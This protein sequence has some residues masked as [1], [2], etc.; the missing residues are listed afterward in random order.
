MDN[1]MKMFL[2]SSGIVAETK[3][4]FLK[5][6]DKRPS[7][8]KVCFIPTAGE[9]EGYHG[10]IAKKE[11][12]DLGIINIKDIDLKN[13]DENGLKNKISKCDI[14][15][16]NGGNTFYLLKWVRHSGFDKII[17]NLLRK[18]KIYVGS[19]AGSYITCPTIEMAAWKYQDRD[20][21]G[22]DD[23]RGLNLVPFLIS[24]HFE[25]K[26]RRIIENAAIKTNYP[27]VALNDRQA[28]IIS[29][30]KV[31]LV[32]RGGKNFFNRFKEGELTIRR[33]LETRQ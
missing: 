9:P 22:L 21:H 7:Q 11:L 8:I 16:V 10:D 4:Y 28:L 27:I 29:N 23:W 26:F 12:R 6:L 25:E 17:T 20:H 31:K 5:L 18:G 1:K 30:K 19:S 32:G 14:I 13:I 15:Y 2:A 24:A 33:K 3:E